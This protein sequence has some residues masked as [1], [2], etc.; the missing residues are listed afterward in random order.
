[1]Y[2]FLFFLKKD[3]RK[4]LLDYSKIINPLLKDFPSEGLDD[5]FYNFFYNQVFLLKNETVEL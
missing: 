5:I 4:L 2:G 1:M 3:A